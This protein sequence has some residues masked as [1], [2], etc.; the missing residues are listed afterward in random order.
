[1]AQNESFPSP[2]TGAGKHR[3]LNGIAVSSGIAIG[4]AL[5]ANRGRAAA[6]Q[7]ALIPPA[8]TG[9]EKKRLTTACENI[10]HEF[11]EARTK[12]LTCPP[13]NPDQAHEQASLLEA[14]AMICRDPKLLASA[15]AMIEGQLVSAEWAWQKAVEAVVATF[16]KMESPYLRE[17]ATDVKTVGARVLARLQ[18]KNGTQVTAGQEKYILFAHDLT[19]ADTLALSPQKIMGIATEMGG[20]TSHTG[21]LAR[22]MRIPCVVGV[23]GLSDLV[24]N[25]D[26]VIID[27]ILGLVII[28]PTEAE[29]HEYA[30][31]QTLFEEYE[32]RLLSECNLPAETEDGIRVFISANIESS[33]EIERVK[34]L[35]GDGIG[36]YRT[37][38][39]Y[40]A[41]QT[42]PTEN[43]LYQ[44]Y[45]K[46]AEQAYPAH[47][48]LRT[49]DI[50]ADKAIAGGE[51]IEED[52]PVLGLRAIR[53]CMRHQDIFR[54]QLRAILRASA[55]GNVEIMFPM[56]SG[57]HELKQAKMV[58]SEVKQELQNEG[59]P[60][61]PCIPVGTMIELPSA[62]FV[63]PELAKEVD[64]FSIGTND[65]IQY[66][67][68]VDRGN[69]YVSY[70]YA[71]LHPAIIQAIRLVVDAAHEAG[72][73]VCVCGEMAADPYGILILLAMGIDELSMTP[74]TIPLAKYIVRQMD[75]EELRELSR[76]IYNSRSSRTTTKLVRQH[77][78]SRIQEELR[79][80][81][82]TESD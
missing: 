1:M 60:F 75:T 81:T 13:P 27:G 17:R 24:S 82:L 57:V 25:S 64:F 62:V 65:L 19:P 69:K 37:E 44:E 47:V 12:L 53:Y 78:Y 4:R 34:K 23:N 71:P 38:F 56:I 46:A 10:A 28:N 14:Y 54:R 72:I 76:Q 52:N 48:V 45:K 49:L 61:N 70:L 63:A 32:S 50:G 5:F 7:I 68:G 33:S 39:G 9:A 41:S 3:I 6:T 55:H 66:T 79:F 77:L 22:S 8:A 36:L 35:G 58:L 15:S 73:P 21:I 42:L 31:T 43:E 11:S 29:L 51:K 18:G 16:E 26:L 30:T 80:I 59:I 67:L 40:M 74:Q 20:F 2:G